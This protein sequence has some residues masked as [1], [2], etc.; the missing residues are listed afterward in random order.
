MASKNEVNKIEGEVS[1]SPAALVVPALYA[2]ANLPAEILDSEWGAVEGLE[3][4]DLLVPKIFH[5]QALSKFAQDGLA[6][7]GDFCDSVTGQVLAKKGEKL[8]IIIFG[9][10]KTMVI[11]KMDPKSLKFFYEETIAITPEN[12]MEMGAKPHVEEIGSETF[13]NNLTYNLYCLI[14][15]LAKELPYVL[16]LGSTK[17]KV[18]RK[19]NTILY[20][21]KELKR[22]G[23][24][25]VFELTSVEDSNDQGTWFNLE[26]S[27]GRDAT[28]EELSRA[29]AWYLKSKTQKFKVV[30]ENAAIVT[31]AAK[32]GSPNSSDDDIP[33]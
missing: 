24:S 21:L 3:T 15:S 6:R 14:P 4:S 18:A 11:S 10:F 2:G 1:T 31:G 19:I 7:P 30:E 33:F 13:K 9:S 26:V 20:K 23:A 22:P 25:V 8:E 12:A 32:G 17:A 5:Q 16:S 27:Q 28:A 29:H